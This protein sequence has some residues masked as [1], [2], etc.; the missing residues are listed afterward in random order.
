LS[1]SFGAHDAVEVLEK[2]FLFVL[3]RDSD[4]RA[5]VEGLNVDLA[6]TAIS[7]GMENLGVCISQ[8]DLG[9]PRPL[10][11]L[12][13]LDCEQPQVRRLELQAKG[14]FLHRD[15]SNLLSLI[16]APYDLF[17]HSDLSLQIAH[18]LSLPFIQSFSRMR[19]FYVDATDGVLGLYIRCPRRRDSLFGTL[20]S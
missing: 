13:F 12:D 16:E 5:I 11:K 7:S 8:M 19:E 20:H 14:P 9:K 2:H 18:T 6:A 15:P 4:A 10:T 3:L 1:W 17:G